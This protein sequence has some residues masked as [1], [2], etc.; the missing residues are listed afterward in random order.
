MYT[1]VTCGC[2]VFSCANS[3]LAAVCVQIQLPVLR[4]LAVMCYKNAAVA[5]EIVKG[6]LLLTFFTRFLFCLVGFLFPYLLLYSFTG[7][8][9]KKKLW[10]NYMEITLREYNS[11]RK[12]IRSP[13][14]RVWPTRQTLAVNSTHAV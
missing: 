3:V 14:T 5:S 11:P 13:G 2:C 10:D 9:K 6:S 12:L 1:T 8:Q 4:S 7:P